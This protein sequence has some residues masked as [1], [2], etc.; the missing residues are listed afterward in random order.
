[1][2]CAARSVPLDTYIP[3]AYIHI[4]P[5]TLT[6]ACLC[7]CEQR[8]QQGTTAKHQIKKTSVKYSSCQQNH[9]HC[10]YTAGWRQ[11]VEIS[12]S[13][14]MWVWVSGSM[15][16]SRFL[17]YRDTVGPTFF[18]QKS[19]LHDFRNLPCLHSGEV[20]DSELFMYPIQLDQ[21]LFQ[22]LTSESPNISMKSV[23]NQKKKNTN[24]ILTTHMKQTDR[25]LY[26]PIC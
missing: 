8:D 24:K 14:E 3:W 12:I 19:L 18:K 15:F 6:K 23:T 13:L 20:R 1:M 11:E 16:F 21:G 22:T 5:C 17:I 25:L 2:S 4:D 26:C 9:I 7:V 10:P